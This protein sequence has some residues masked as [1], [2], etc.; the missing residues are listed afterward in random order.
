[1]PGGGGKK[2]GAGE[3]CG[4]SP[5]KVACGVPTAQSAVFV[6]GDDVT[7]AGVASP[8]RAELAGDSASIA[9]VTPVKPPVSVA[10][11]KLFFILNVKTLNFE[12]FQDLV[13][14][15]SVRQMMLKHQPMLESYLVIEEFESE[16]AATEYLLQVKRLTNLAAGA[17]LVNRTDESPIG[18]GLDMQLH[19]GSVGDD[20]ATVDNF[21]ECL[22][23]QP[24]DEDDFPFQPLASINPPQSSI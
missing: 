21:Q 9:A 3:N 1:M 24:A 7:Y 10:E 23:A 18:L 15:T 4:A 5:P 20:V 13:K 16:A 6:D 11:S 14:A 8:K 12:V 22:A 19:G 17:S 2:R